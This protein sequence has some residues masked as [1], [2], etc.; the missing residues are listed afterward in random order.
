EP[1]PLAAGTGAITGKVLDPQG[2][3]IAG[4]HIAIV[5]DKTG[6]S[7][8]TATN[9]AGSFGRPNL[10]AGSYHVRF[11]AQWFRRKDQVVQVNSM[12]AGRLDAKLQMMVPAGGPEIMAEQQGPPTGAIQGVVMEPS[13]EIVPARVLI[14][15]KATGARFETT[16][17]SRGVYRLSNLPAGKYE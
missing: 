3:G 6:W 5:E 17:D 2:V 14:T 9:C 7:Y 4:A 12:E 13:G 16:T 8:D 15:D 11:E 10:P 1:P